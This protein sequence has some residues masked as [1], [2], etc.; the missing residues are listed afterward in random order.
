MSANQQPPASSTATP[1]ATASPDQILAANQIF[2]IA[3]TTTSAQ[4]DAIRAEMIELQRR[5]GLPASLLD[6]RIGGIT[7]RAVFD[8]TGRR[9][10][11]ITMA[12][13]SPVLSS[14]GSPV[15]SPRPAPAPVPSQPDGTAPV[16]ARSGPA[17]SSPQPG[18]PAPAPAHGGAAPVDQ[19]QTSLVSQFNETASF[20]DRHKTLLL[21]TAGLVV[22]TGVAAYLMTSADGEK[23]AMDNATVR[24]AARLL[25]ISPDSDVQS[26]RA[27]AARALQAYPDDQ[28]RRNAIIEARDVMIRARSP[29]PA[30]G[31][32]E[33]S[34]RG[35]KMSYQIVT[36]GLR[37]R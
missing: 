36:S 30:S 21:V 32:G 15:P 25:G 8:L 18:G 5:M 35:R 16:P 33:V 37:G 20:F 17:P 26:I 2:S 11:G 6:G 34:S 24:Y 27:A 4:R 13:T 7:A 22:A 10:P 14:P 9:I 3:T 19:L 23:R 29:R 28:A 12:E 31:L 1:S